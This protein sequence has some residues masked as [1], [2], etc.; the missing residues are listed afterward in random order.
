MPRCRRLS[1]SDIPESIPLYIYD[2]L[3]GNWTKFIKEVVRPKGYGVAFYLPFLM[4]YV[5]DMFQA[6]NY[7]VGSAEKWHEMVTLNLQICIH[8]ICSNNAVDA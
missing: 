5:H 8:V 4:P 2:F 7:W 6:K 3:S 1:C